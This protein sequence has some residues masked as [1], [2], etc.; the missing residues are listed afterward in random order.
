MSNELVG[1]PDDPEIASEGYEPG[2]TGGSRRLA[3]RMRVFSLESSFFLHAVGERLGM[4]ATDFACLTLLLIEGPVSAGAL[5]ERAGLT[6]GAI[7]GLIDR[8]ERSG[9]VR[10]VA[11]PADRR[12]VMVEPIMERAAALRPLYDP[13]LQEA[14][15]VQHQFDPPE[16]AAIVDFVEQSTEMLALQV[17]RL[18][19]GPEESGPA[20]GT[21]RSGAAGVTRVA[22]EGRLDGYLHVR[23]AGTDLRITADNLAESLCVVDFGDRPAVVTAHGGRVN[24]SRSGRGRWRSRNNRAQIVLHC[25]VAWE[26]VLQGGASR[27]DIDLRGGRLTSLG[28]AGGA[29]TVELALPE[30]STLVAV[31][32]SG[33]ASRVMASRPAGV[34]VSA[35]VRGGAVSVKVDGVSLTSA[36]GRAT[37]GVAAGAGYDFDINGGASS[38]EVVER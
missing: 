36:G 20:D 19:F 7:T 12:R 29:N 34:R 37:L 10:R 35:R 18:R 27:L 30:P 5:A 38:V 31:H 2:V 17:R 21:S 33:G 13:M 22:R 11:D 16:Q 8:L 24:V 1:A 23:G 28:I 3:E 32:L 14:A 26:I 4:T 25:D 9:W 15:A 6:T